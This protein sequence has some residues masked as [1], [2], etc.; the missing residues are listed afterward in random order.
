MIEK[1]S[2]K[3]KKRKIALAGGGAANVKLNRRI[4]ESNKIDEIHI[5]PAMGDD[6]V[7]FGAAIH[8]LIRRKSIKS[9]R[10]MGIPYWGFNIST[11]GLKDILNSLDQSLF[12]VQKHSLEDLSKIFAKNI[13]SG[14]IGSICNGSAEFGPRALG[15]RSILA[16]PTKKDIRDR[17]NKAFKKREWFQPFCPIISIEECPK[18]LKKWYINKHMTCAFSVKD[19]AYEEIPSCVHVD[20]TARVQVLTKDDNFFLNLLM[21]ELSFLG[22]PRVLLNTSFNLHGRS[23]VRTASDALKD[24]LDCDLDF[25]LLGDI[26][27][28][29]KR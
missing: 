17:I 18:Y 24:F 6:G 23:M 1:I 15:N 21:E 27:I 25:M 12:N 8:P 19:L 29:R 4:F 3:Y 2:V 20:G 5:F 10:N 26:F 13:Y 11:N 14:R 22:H 9:L 7:A 16:S 28:E